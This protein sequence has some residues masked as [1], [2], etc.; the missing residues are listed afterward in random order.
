MAMESYVL[1]RT[2]HF[3]S[4]VAW[5]IVCFELLQFEKILSVALRMY[6][7]A[8]SQSCKQTWKDSSLPS[9]LKVLN[10]L[11]GLPFQSVRRPSHQ[12]W[13]S[14]FRAVLQSSRSTSLAAG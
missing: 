13:S 4:S 7:I 6:D 12:R 3:S 1:Y 2:L 5:L 14:K 8:N 10:M 11:S 9:Y